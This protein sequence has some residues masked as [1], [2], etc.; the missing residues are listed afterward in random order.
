MLW[1]SALFQLFTV[2]LVFNLAFPAS[3]TAEVACNPKYQFCAGH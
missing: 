2:I 3:L 1:R